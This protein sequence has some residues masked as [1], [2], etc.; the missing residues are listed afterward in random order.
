[1]TDASY[2]RTID[3]RS[4]RMVEVAPEFENE[5]PGFRHVNEAAALR[6]G[7]VRKAA[8]GAPQDPAEAHA[9]AAEREVANAMP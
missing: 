6:L 4:E 5:P 8:A 3:G 7:L 1:M 9:Q 2:V